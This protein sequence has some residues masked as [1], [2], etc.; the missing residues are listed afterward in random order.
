MSKMEES[1]YIDPRKIREIELLEDIWNYGDV[2]LPRTEAS[3]ITR[4]ENMVKDT[5][6]FGYLP[7]RLLTLT[8]KGIDGKVYENQP[9]VFCDGA[10]DEAV[11]WEVPQNLLLGQSEGNPDFRLFTYKII[12][13]E[14]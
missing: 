11:I 10:K 8:I 6:K 9:V 3:E 7:F 4:L 5:K 13:S 2:Q 14:E 12:R 1:L